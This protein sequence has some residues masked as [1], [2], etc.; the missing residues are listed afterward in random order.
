VGL[1]HDGVALA[2]FQFFLEKATSQVLTVAIEQLMQNTGHRI[3]EVDA[4]AIAKGPGSYTG[5]RIGTATAKGL[6]Y[7]LQKPLIAIST[8]EAM[9]CEVRRFY[10]SAGYYFC[11][12]IDARRMEVY[13][14]IYNESLETVVPVQAKIIDENSFDEIEVNHEIIF[15]GDGA[16]K[17]REK[18][19]HHPKSVFIDNVSPSAH[20]VGLLAWEAFQKNQFENVETFEPFYLKEFVSTK[21]IPK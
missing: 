15:F 8:L 17:C 21:D 2:T 16:A 1:H 10:P 6:S 18:L 11:P 12:M 19:A 5:L 13:C 7:A 20:Y 3:P 4:I 9:T 14:A